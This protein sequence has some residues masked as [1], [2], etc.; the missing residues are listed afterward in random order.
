MKK[1][2]IKSAAGIVLALA[3]SL[4][5]PDAGALGPGL[6]PSLVYGMWANINDIVLAIGG[7]VLADPVVRGRVGDIETKPFFAKEPGDLLKKIAGFHDRL[8]RLRVRDGLKANHLLVPVGG[9]A[10]VG[11]IFIHSGHVLDELAE[12]LI[13]KTGPNKL[14]TRFYERRDFSDRTFSDIYGL[15]DLADRRLTMILEKPAPMSPRRP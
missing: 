9:Q 12:W 11:D 8:N 2:P 4:T 13:T 5:T 15:I 6:T 10:A 1:T 14:I 3:L 7:A